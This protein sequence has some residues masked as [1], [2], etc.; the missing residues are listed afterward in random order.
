[1]NRR[2]FIAGV[3]GAAAWPL[4]AWGQRDHTL[5][6]G[7]LASANPDDPEHQAQ[8]LALIGKLET[9][10]WRVGVNLIID[11][12]SGLGNPELVRQ[13]AIELVSKTPDVILTASV[14]N[15]LALRE[16]T[17][18]IPIVFAAASDPVDVGLVDSYA[19]P[20]GNVTGFTSNAE[21]H[22]ESDAKLLQILREIAPHINRVAVIFT[23][24]DRS[25][26]GRM[27]SVEAGA[28]ALKVQAFSIDVH[29]DAEIENEIEKFA[30]EPNSGLVVFPSPFTV[31]H[32]VSIIRSAY[33]RKLP[34]ISRGQ[35]TDNPRLIGLLAG[36]P[37]AAIAADVSAF[38]DGLRNLGYVESKDFRVAYRYGE[39]HY[40]RMPRLAE[41][42][43]ELKPDLILAA[44]G[45]PS[46]LAAKAI[47]STIPIVCPIL[48]NPVGLGLA[49]SDARPGGNV[50]GLSIFV[51]GLAAKQLELAHDMLP[52]IKRFGLLSN[53]ANP[54]MVPEELEAESSA[55]KLGI[56]IIK[57][58]VRQPDELHSA[59]KE[60][61]SEKCEAVVVLPD[62]MFFGERNQLASLANAARLP[63]IY[64]FRQHVEAGGMISY[65]VD[66]R[67]NFRRAAS[68]V[69]KI[70]KG[71]PP[72]ELPV[73][74][75]TKLELVINLKTAKVISLDLPP[76]LLARASRFIGYFSGP[77]FEDSANLT[78]S[79]QITLADHNFV[80]RNSHRSLLR[81]SRCGSL[82]V[83]AS[84]C[85]WRRLERVGIPARRREAF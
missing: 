9:L 83:L 13:A 76:A 31:K 4:V 39:G 14:Q 81:I 29:D 50:T 43:I 53:I 16:Q 70:W 54:A 7:W 8:A 5:H 17:R 40:D 80:C 64:A 67:N 24:A 85:S 62:G 15:V 41:E 74:F 61:L 78:E 75:P 10:G 32:Y 35:N 77:E 37:P 34:T 19:H 65:G 51:A 48:S 20:G 23:S 28:S 60:F 84:V 12:R 6:L 49:E 46:V 71:A 52:A 82:P 3:G 26:L 57:V 79:R 33:Q 63:D 68:Y 38:L 25:W 30:Q 72:G 73:E 2:A 47:S 22:Y 21:T 11:Y 18:T 1:M 56:S 59:F 27:R 45:T 69:D 36:P 66:V 42:L 58:A 55:P 44:G